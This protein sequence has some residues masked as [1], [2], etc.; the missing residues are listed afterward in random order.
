MKFGVDSLVVCVDFMDNG[1]EILKYTSIIQQ[2]GR[3]S[4]TRGECLGHVFID[5]DLYP[6]G[7]DNSE[8]YMET[9]LSNT[10]NTEF[11]KT[12][13]YLKEEFEKGNPERK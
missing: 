12:F 7:F 11:I 10:M 3:S 9:K 2:I 6:V 8:I 13:N 5:D 1:V 4:R